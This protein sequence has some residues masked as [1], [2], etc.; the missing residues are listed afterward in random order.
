[1]RVVVALG[2]N[3]ILRRGEPMSVANQRASIATAC[4]PL[5]AIAAEHD[6][7]VSHGNG[8]QVGLLALQAA[9]Y[10]DV[11]AYPFDVLGA[12]TEGMLG[13]LIEQELGNRIG[14][15]RVIVTI[16][17]RTVVDAADPAFDDPTKFVGP[18]Y[19][20]ETATSMSRQHGWT[21]RP[22]GLS[23][24]RVVPSPTPL[25]I[26][27]TKPIEWIL[28][29]GGIV[30]CAGGGGVP[31]AFDP[32]SDVMHGVEAV[33]DKDSASAVLAGDLHADLL[34][35]A[36][37]VDGVYSGWCTPDQRLIVRAH[38]DALDASVFPDGSMRPKVRAAQQFAREG[39][40]D[41]VIG[42]LTAIDGLLARTAGTVVSLAADGVEYHVGA[43]AR[44][45]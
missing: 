26:L 45:T 24:R 27:E 1:M 17:T 13:Y 31:T 18:A 8:P 33:V 21:M 22:D 10:D 43:A 12:Q 9:A 4:G 14:N 38:P 16:V 40:G 34:I 20:R 30:I 15:D 3:A 42:S 2:G 41:A 19:D 6:L 35:I 39:R 32:G 37:D 5:A 7:V 44:S 28:R 25:R 23:F 29:E 36:T 11:S